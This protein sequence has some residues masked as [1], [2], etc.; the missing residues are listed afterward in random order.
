MTTPHETSS[1][2]CR[3]AAIWLADIVGFTRLAAEDETLALRLVEILQAAAVEAHEGKIVKF[4]GDGVLAEFASAQ[5]GAV[6][7]IQLLLRFGQ[8]TEGWPQGPHQLRLGMHLG[9]GVNRAS[10]LEGLAEPGRLLVSED[11]YR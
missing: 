7:G 9:D 6:S 5:G 4:M 10:R 11:L 3:L 8:L 2:S 1:G